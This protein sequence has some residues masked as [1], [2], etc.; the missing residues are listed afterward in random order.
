MS[1][2]LA[3]TDGAV[4]AVKEIVSSSEEVAETGGLRM[5]AEREGTKR[6]SSSAS[7]PCPPRTTR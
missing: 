6:T 4:Q 7:F 5:V 1:A 3:L 2:L